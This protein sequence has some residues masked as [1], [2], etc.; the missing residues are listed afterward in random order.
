LQEFFLKMLRHYGPLKG[1]PEEALADSFAIGAFLAEERDAIP[2][3]LEAR[4][5]FWRAFGVSSDDQVLWER[6]LQAGHGVASSVE[7]P[8]YSR[9]L[10]A[11]PGL[12]ESS[13]DPR[14]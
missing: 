14:H 3:S 4:V 8:P 11:D 9:A 6:E 12:L 2:V 7:F 1:V 10:E 13:W 5:S